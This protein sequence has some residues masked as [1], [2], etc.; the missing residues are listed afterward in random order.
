MRCL[1][2]T[3]PPVDSPT[4][5]DAATE[6][7]KDVPCLHH[8]GHAPALR[9]SRTCSSKAM[10]VMR[11]SGAAVLTHQHR[12]GSSPLYQTRLFVV[13][14]LRV[15]LEP[16]LLRVT[17]IIPCYMFVGIVMGTSTVAQMPLPFP[18]GSDGDPTPRGVGF[19]LSPELRHSS[20]GMAG[21]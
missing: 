7:F 1:T 17:W 12:D 8:H 20:F 19:R 3:F 16:K 2:S 5:G 14:F 6:I 10:P 11:D 4:T 21:Q 13:A 18:Y 15:S 9:A